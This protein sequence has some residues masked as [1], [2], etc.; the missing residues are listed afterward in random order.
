MEEEPENSVEIFKVVVNDE[1]HY[2]IWCSHVAIPPGWHDEGTQGSK[3][4]CLSYIGPVW[5]NMR[6]HSLRRALD[7]LASCRARKRV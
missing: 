5:T 4:T 6:P 3:E 1:G 7:G 2:S